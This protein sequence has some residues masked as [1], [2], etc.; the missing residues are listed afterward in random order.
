MIMP[1]K[2]EWKELVLDFL[3]KKK[4]GKF[5]VSEIFGDWESRPITHAP[6]E[7]EEAIEELKEEDKIEFGMN[8]EGNEWFK[9]KEKKDNHQ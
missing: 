7:L 1:T 5:L 6:K 8:D 2:E 9:H 4:G 3:R